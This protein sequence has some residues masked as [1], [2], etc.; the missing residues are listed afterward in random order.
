MDIAVNSWKYWQDCGTKCKT[1]L[2]H[3]F[4]SPR[5]APPLGWKVLTAGAAERVWRKADARGAEVEGVPPSLRC[6]WRIKWSSLCSHESSEQESNCSWELTPR[7]GLRAFRT[8]EA[9]RQQ[10]A[11]GKPE[12]FVTKWCIVEKCLPLLPALCWTLLH[13]KGV[14][15]FCWAWEGVLDRWDFVRA[16]RS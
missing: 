13:S 16:H 1:L 12:I 7:D 2:E 8:A 6:G 4:W 11:N 10:E 14:G 15:E 9:C 5:P 3:F